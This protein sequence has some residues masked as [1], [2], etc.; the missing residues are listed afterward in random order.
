M[1]VFWNTRFAF[2]TN[3]IRIIKATLKIKSFISLK[4][5]FVAAINVQHVNATTLELLKGV[6]LSL[7]L[8]LQFAPASSLYENDWR[9]EMY[10][11]LNFHCTDPFKPPCRNVNVDV[12]M[13][14]SLK[15][16]RLQRDGNN[17]ITHIHSAGLELVF[18][19][20]LT[21]N[22]FSHFHCVCV[23]PVYLH[24]QRTPSPSGHYILWSLSPLLNP[25]ASFRLNWLGQNMLAAHTGLTPV[26]S[27]MIL[28]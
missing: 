28:C 24:K 5:I 22:G 25:L 17:T 12:L 13:F 8:G 9:Y 2:I 21:F 18:L 19:T 3:L 1:S 26:R 14:V 15:S 16:R 20:A 27:H 7:K 10:Q 23:F 6:F 4:I 11:N